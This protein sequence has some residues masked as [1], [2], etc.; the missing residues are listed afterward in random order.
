ML[1][2]VIRPITDPAP[3]LGSVGLVGVTGVTGVTGVV[4]LGSSKFS[5]GFVGHGLHLGSFSG[6][7]G[8]VGQATGVSLN[9][10]VCVQLAPPTVY[11]S[12]S[13]MPVT[14]ATML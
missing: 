11:F 14:V 1:T 2:P 4:H 13:T 12:P 8:L 5:S 10:T 7:L 6:R 9:D 3:V